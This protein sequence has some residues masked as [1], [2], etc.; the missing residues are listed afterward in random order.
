METIK[1]LIAKYRKQLLIPASIVLAI[2][3]L[4]QLYFLIEITPR[5]ND[6]CIWSPQQ[7]DKDQAGFVFTDVKF[8]GVTWNA[9]IRDGDLLLEINGR[10]IE[11]LRVATTEL[12][13]MQS[14]DTAIYRVSRNGRV[15]DAKVEVKKLIQF[16]GL[17]YL[18]ISGIWFIVGAIVI[19][20]K[21][22][23]YSQVLFFRIGGALVLFSLFNVLQSSQISNPI[24]NYPYIA[25]IVDAIQTLGGV[26]LPFFV[27]HF[28]W[29]FP[30]RFS[31]IDKKYTVKILYTTPVLLF[32]LITVF[33][34]S[35][36]YDNSVARDYFFG[37]Y[38][39]FIILL[40]ITSAVVGLVSL[41]INYLK[42]KTKN[43]RTAI[44]I[45]L[46][47]YAIGVISIIY[48]VV[49]YRIVQ[50]NSVPAST[51]YNSPE[52]FSPIILI[53]LIPVAFAFSIFKYSLMDVTDVLKNTLL[54]GAATVSIAALYFLLVYVLG[55]SVSSA[56]GTEYQG[57]IAGFVFI[58]AAIIF[59][60]TKERLQEVITRRFYPE[61]FAYQRVL[62]K[63][64]SDVATI[65]GLGN[66]LKSTTNT[67]VESL[68][69]EQFGILL[70]DRQKSNLFHYAEGTGFNEYPFDV[71][72]SIGNLAQFI[73]SK[74]DAGLVLVIEETDFNYVFPESQSRLES[75]EIFTIIPLIIQSK[76][77]GFTLFGLKHSGSKFS[78]KDL[79][80]LSAAANQLAVAIENARLYE[81][82][83][84]KL[85]MDRDLENARKIQ[86]SLLPV[87]APD[88]QNLDI[89]GKMLPAMHVGGD[90][91]DLIKVSET[92]LFAVIGDVS[93]KGL[94]ASFY[95]SK[96]QTMMQLYCNE[97]LSPKEV[98]VEINRSMYKSIEK[99][100]F[101]TVSV[102]LIDT[103]SNIITFARAG[104]TPLV[105][106]N[107]EEIKNY[108]SPGIGIG[109]EKGDIFNSV[110]EEITIPLKS[111]S[112]IS[113]YSDGVTEL[114]NDTNKLFGED[115]FR[116][117]LKNNLNSNASEIMKVLLQDLSRHKKNAPQND[118]ITLVLIKVN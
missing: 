7:K 50:Y 92:K 77:I 82:E 40:V 36:I 63:F 30:N 105:I 2:M 84:E 53:S 16:G 23:G 27:V 91:Y 55:Q 98:L 21:P 1:Y 90:Y 97:N 47:A 4:T 15:F 6:E 11:D 102:A 116:F 118:D 57:I 10:K 72:A 9:G 19:N 107:E 60:S 37:L 114:M 24:Y 28:F 71:E 32:I 41:F 88:F 101:I 85:K 14:G 94:S 61:Q 109:L 22:D 115:N 46:V 33:K 39:Q 67:F 51:I 68:K 89:C 45:I 62:V 80:L 43:E 73:L 74:K 117:I 112:L 69:V 35:F 25:V 87:E 13:N 58:G 111:G 100:W 29:I 76:V 64:S 26:F 38:N 48:T 113:L 12:Y 49:L 81:S 34:V 52:L 75:E 79:D 59:Q 86:D 103:E 31:I 108:T 104:H 8:E 20:A 110:V 17:A 3:I 54:Y 70:K 42:L 5:P 18:L 95:M 78:G 96:L 65:V 93:G 44:F 99:N 106:V 66:I 83:A 56:I